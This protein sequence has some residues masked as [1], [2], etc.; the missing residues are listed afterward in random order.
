MPAEDRAD[1][2]LRLGIVIPALNEELTVAQVVTRCR[3]STR[4][5]G[6]VRV[7]V[8]DNGSTDRTA[9]LAQ[10][11]GAE[12][13]QVRRRGYGN[14]CLGALDHLGEWPDVLVFLDADGSSPPE[15]IPRLLQPLADG[16]ADLVLGRRPAGAA[17][18]PPQRWGT[19]LAVWLVNRRWGADYHDM[20]PFRAIRRQVLAEL[21]M[22]DRTW[23]WTIEMQILACRKGVRFLEVPVSWEPR[24]A[25]RSKISGTLSGVMRAGGRILWTV[26]RYAWRRTGSIPESSRNSRSR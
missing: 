16:H 9:L 7:V 14:A 24:L 12:V 1:V 22:T 15:E 21:A 13:V 11:A 19:R 5:W 4:E 23:G 17:M 10:E 8:A 20:G 18:T 25:G 26:G 2:D 3:E 6:Q